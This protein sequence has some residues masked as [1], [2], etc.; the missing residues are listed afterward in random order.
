M[1]SKDK[2]KMPSQAARRP[3]ARPQIEES[4]GFERLVLTCVH[5]PDQPSCM[6]N[7]RTGA[8]GPTLS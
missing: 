8:G 3:Y 6:P 5:V 1:D 4:G 2:S 7:P